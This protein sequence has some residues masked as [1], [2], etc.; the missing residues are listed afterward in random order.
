[1]SYEIRD[2]SLGTLASPTSTWNSSTRQY[3][4]VRQSTAPEFFK[5]IGSSTSSI[6]PIGIVQNKP[7]LNESAE[8]WLPGC[9]SKI[10]VGLGGVTV[11]KMFTI[12]A[13]GLAR[14]TGAA[15]V[16]NGSAMYGPVLQTGV[17]G[18]IVTVSFAYVGQAT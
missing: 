12:A 7:R 14:S 11:G 5:D 6:R 10:Q 17:A 15:N 3:R 13:S 8:I 16:I 9:I 2:M 1:M 18:D 4:A